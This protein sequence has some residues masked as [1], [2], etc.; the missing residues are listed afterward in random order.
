MV[1]RNVFKPTDN[2]LTVVIGELASE[3]VPLPLI[4]L[5]VP[6]AGNMGVV[7]VK[8]TEEVVEQMDWSGPALAAVWAE[9][10]TLTTT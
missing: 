1:Y 6:V 9:L 3:N 5:Q 10:N 8:F 4:T 7:P 2:P